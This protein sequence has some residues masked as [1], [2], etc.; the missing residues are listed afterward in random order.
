MARPAEVE[1]PEQAIRS[2]QA[3]LRLTFGDAHRLGKPKHLID[4]LAADFSSKFGRPPKDSDPLYYDPKQRQPVAR[5]LEDML[6]E[7][8]GAALDPN[9]RRF[10]ES[11]AHGSPEPGA[12]AQ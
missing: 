10:V 2:L 12:K 1:I 9:L 3:Q 11:V 4:G 5:T 8:I 6:A 7:L